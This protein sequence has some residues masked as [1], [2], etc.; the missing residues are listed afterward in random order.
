[1]CNAFKALLYSLCIGFSFNSKAEVSKIREKDSP[2]LG[3][4]SFSL[5]A[6][7]TEFNISSKSSISGSHNGQARSE[8]A[9]GIGIGYIYQNLHGIGFT[10]QTSYIG[11]NFTDSSTNEKGQMQILRVEANLNYTFNSTFSIKGGINASKITNEI[12][13]LSNSY[14]TFN[15]G[16]G[17]Q[18]LL[19]MN[20]NHWLGIDLG[21]TEINLPFTSSYPQPD[22]LMD[23]SKGNLKVF[24]PELSLYLI[25]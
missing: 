23:H 20:I 19:S 17:Y 24:G 8:S 7:P 18:A 21:Y 25:F 4:V 13:N 5:L 14:A 16:L 2:K 12:G 22:N 1:M 6:L 9:P 15:P 10:T 11:Q 3:G